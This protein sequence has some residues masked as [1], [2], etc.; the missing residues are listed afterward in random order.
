MLTRLPDVTRLLD[1]LEKSGLVDRRR[2]LE[3]RR[4]VH[5]TIPPRTRRRKRAA[6][7]IGPAG[8]S[9]TFPTVPESGSEGAHGA[10]PTLVESFEKIFG[11][12]RIPGRH[13]SSAECVRSGGARQMASEGPGADCRSTIVLR[14]GRSSEMVEGRSVESPSK[15]PPSRACG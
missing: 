12:R 8:S 9:A 10:Q 1:R 4:Q 3:D 11:N 5:V 7:Q 13:S 6:R 14:G 2:G 15:F